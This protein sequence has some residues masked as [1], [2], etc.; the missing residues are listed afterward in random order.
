MPSSRLQSC[1]PHW[2]WLRGLAEG[3]AAWICRQ[4]LVSCM[5]CDSLVPCLENNKGVMHQ[6][7]FP[8]LFASLSLDLV[9]FLN[10]CIAIFTL[11]TGLKMMMPSAWLDTC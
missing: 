3:L 11:L 10:S 1:L 7:C 4:M 2:S 9:E 5:G 8:W 6:L